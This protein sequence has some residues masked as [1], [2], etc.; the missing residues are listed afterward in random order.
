MEEQ[1]KDVSFLD[2]YIFYHLEHDHNVVINRKV[3]YKHGIDEVLEECQRKGYP[4]KLIEMD[5]TET[6]Q[7]RKKKRG[8]KSKYPATTTYILERI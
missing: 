6:D 1:E 3:L 7:S 8:A 2:D 4:V 5:H